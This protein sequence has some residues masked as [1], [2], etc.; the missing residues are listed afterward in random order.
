MAGPEIERLVHLLARLPG[1]GPR[2]ARRAVLFLLRRR[3]QAMSPLIDALSEAA[4]NVRTCSIC[5]NYDSQD[6][7]AVC[8]DPARDRS[9]ICVIEDVAGLWAME[10]SG[11]FRGS[12]HVLG[13][14]LSALDGIGPDDLAIDRLVQR[15]AAAEVREVILATGVTVDGQTTAHYVADRLAGC[16]VA[17]SVLA[18]GVPMGGELDF[19]DDGTIGAAMRSRRPV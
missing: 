14:V 2:S 9:V 6:P 12:Y 3:E 19:L 7:C 8:A 18:Q 10:R 16:T 1:L 4:A 5:G 15:A 13:G 17:V 11:V